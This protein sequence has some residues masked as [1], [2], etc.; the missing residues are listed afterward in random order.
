MTIYDSFNLPFP[1][2]DLIPKRVAEALQLS[3][4]RLDLSPTFGVQRT[5]FERPGVSNFLPTEPK[6]FPNVLILDQIRM[7]RFK[8]LMLVDIC[9]CWVFFWYCNFA[10]L[11]TKPWRWNSAKIFGESWQNKIQNGTWPTR[12]LGRSRTVDSEKKLHQ[13][14]GLQHCN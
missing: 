9:C 4:E 1:V 2:L 11:H 12:L 8:Y 5:S 3:T 6:S 14:R 7:I 10:F 13:L